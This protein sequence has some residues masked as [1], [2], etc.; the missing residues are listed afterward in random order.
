MTKP[1]QTGYKCIS[2]K[3]HEG[4]LIGYQ[5]AVQW[6]NK[7]LYEYIPLA[8]SPIGTL[9][10]AVAVRNEFERQLG[11][12]RT[13]HHM[14]GTAAGVVFHDRHTVW[15]GPTWVAY[16][17]VGGVKHATSFAASTHGGKAK[18]RKAAREWRRQKEVELFG[19]VF[20]R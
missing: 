8:I 18:A 4:V 3:R 17:E 14:I 10:Q 15:G 5:V 12:P 16:I 7:K 19:Q 13:E 6:R 2:P 11:K 9:Q 1:N 20:Q